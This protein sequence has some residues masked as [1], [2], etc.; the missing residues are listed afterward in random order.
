MKRK[1]RDP[2]KRDLMTPKYRKRVIPPK[3]NT[4]PRKRKHKEN[5]NDL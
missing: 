3:R 2:M 5:P 4:I 1:T